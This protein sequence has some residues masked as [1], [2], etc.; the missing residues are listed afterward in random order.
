[1]IP[2]GHTSIANNHRNEYFEIRST[3]S[4]H[5]ALQTVVNGTNPLSCCT[6][7]GSKL[8]TRTPLP[9][10]TTLNAVTVGPPVSSSHIPVVQGHTELA[11]VAALHWHSLDY[12]VA[13]ACG[14]WAC[15]IEQCTLRVLVGRRKVGESG[16]SCNL[17]LSDK[18]LSYS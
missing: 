8:R 15:M 9:R 6:S 18:F 13:Y 2:P 12:R 17:I 3:S 7:R 4:F 11:K 10:V 5:Q 14:V 1:M 16:A